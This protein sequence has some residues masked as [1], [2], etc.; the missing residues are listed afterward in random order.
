MNNVGP[1]PQDLIPDDYQSEY[2]VAAYEE[3]I[4]LVENGGEGVGTGKHGRWVVQIMTGFLNSHQAGSTLVD[5]P[6]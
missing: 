1:N 4:D 3:L 5:V 6:Q 2:Y